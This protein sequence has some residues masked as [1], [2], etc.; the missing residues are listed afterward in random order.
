MLFKDHFQTQ[1][2]NKIKEY[3]IYD[4][5]HSPAHVL[6]YGDFDAD[7]MFVSDAPGLVEVSTGIPFTGKARN[8]IVNAIRDIGLKKGEYYFTYLVKQPINKSSK[9]DAMNDNKCIDLFLEEIELVNPKII[10]SMGFYVTKILT[11]QYEIYDEIK[12][13]KEIHG[14]GYVVKAKKKR[15][16]IIR[17]KRY[18]IPTWNPAIDNQI[19]NMQFEKDVLTIKAV[20]NLKAL[21]FD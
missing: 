21:L 7:V 6:G 2:N 8:K 11:R 14:N 13:L 15:T 1:L 19:M 5:K 9:L 10:C 16:K 17:S 4:S 20:D 12:S 3:S 18:L